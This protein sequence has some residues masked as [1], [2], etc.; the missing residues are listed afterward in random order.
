MGGT[1]EPPTQGARPRAGSGA[2]WS[3]ARPSDAPTRA[4]YAVIDIGSNSVRLVVYDEL[5]RAPLPRFN[6]K[7][8]CRLG[9]GLAE[10][11]EIQP[12]ASGGRSRPRAGSA[13]SPTPWAWSRVDVTATEAMRRAT[14]G[15]RL[16]AAIRE[17]A[18]LE[19]R[20]LS[21]A[22]EARF[23]APGV[24]SGF[25]RPIGWSATWAA[26]ASRS[27]RRW[28]TGSASGGSA[29][30]WGPAGGGAAGGGA[31]EA[32]RRIDAL[33]KDSLPPALTQP[34]FYPV[35][36]GWRALA[37][38][39]MAAVAAPVRWC[40]ATRWTPARRARSPRRSGISPRPRWRTW[41]ASPSAAGADPAGG[42]A[43]DGPGLKHLAPERVVFS[44]L[45]L[46][47]GWLYAQ[48]PEAERYL[49]PLV[50]GA[51]LVG[52]PMAR[53]P[54]FAPALVRWTD[55]LF[56]GRDPGRAAPARRRL[57]ALRHRLARPSRR[58]RRGELP[59]PAPVPVHR[60]RP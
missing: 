52:L 7:S 27:P 10:T 45:G 59:P 22:E 56:P 3:C 23:A 30:R 49:D 41:P 32:K 38:A 19:V 54:G 31:G 60:P 9:E 17:E 35:G 29:C 28:T 55:G 39:Q 4:P 13:P 24:I 47:E 2:R 34:V 50:E 12:R 21:G 57:R 53:V 37:K 6:E 16:V 33:L 58:A 42:G 40:T 51:Q 43:G 25:Y 20:V 44:A 26:A 18:G 46:R 1:D 48:L 15:D 11:G 14:N 36:G 5:G 8:L